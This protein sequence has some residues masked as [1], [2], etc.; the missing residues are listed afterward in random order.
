M[1]VVER[2]KTLLIASGS[3]WVLWL[4]IG[5]SVIS[6]A[7]IVERAWQLF[8]LRVDVGGLRVRLVRALASGGFAEARDVVA[9]V[10][11][12]AASVAL[13]MMRQGEDETTATQAEDVMHAELLVQKRALE[14]RFGFLA[15]LGS[16]APFVGLLGTVIGILRAFEALGHAQGTAAMAPQAVMSSIAE[17]LVA[18]AVGLAVAIPAVFAYNSFQR[19]VKNA[20]TDAEALGLEVLAHLHGDARPVRAIPVPGESGP[21]PSESPNS[22]RGRPALARVL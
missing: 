10:S 15:T 20:L 5:V 13:R 17:A 19:T 2:G 21:V 3:E 18:T 9:T 1:N 11:H 22:R 14:R 6:L 16:N 4:L 8:A 12:P 7:V